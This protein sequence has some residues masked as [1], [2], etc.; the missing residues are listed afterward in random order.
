[1]ALLVG[2]ISCRAAAPKL[3]SV[4]RLLTHLH[5]LRRNL[6]GRSLGMATA[7]TSIHWEEQVA[8]KRRRLLASIPP[9]W[10]ISPVPDDQL[11]VLDVPKTCGLLT[12]RELEITNTTD[13][14]LILR[15]LATAEWS[16]VEVTTAFSKRAVV[17]HQVV[18]YI[19]DVIIM[20][21]A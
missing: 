5:P 12:D 20:Y 10:I 1:M 3:Y 21:R 16:A 7:V 11:N 4:T 8:D 13:V 19:V 14:S 17:A 15:K 9:A 6:Q 2:S 18:S